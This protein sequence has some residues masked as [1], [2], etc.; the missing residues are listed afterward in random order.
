MTTRKK[1]HKKGGVPVAKKIAE[2]HPKLFHYTSAS[3]LEG[4][5]K[6]Q[7]LWATHAAFLNDSAEIRAF[8]AR[9]PEVLRPAVD[10]GI[11]KLLE[12]PANRELVKKVGGRAAAVDE[13]VRGIA[14]GMYAAL[15]GTSATPPFVEPY[16]LS[17]CTAATRQVT[18]HG[19]LSQWRGYGRDGG[20]AIEF[21]TARLDSLLG[22]EGAKWVYDLF[23]GDV[24]YSSDSSEKLRE[25]LG[26]SIDDIKA[27]VTQFLRTAGE[28]ETL[29]KIYSALI[30]CAC[31]YKHWGFDEEKEVRVVAIPPN[32]EIVQEMKRRGRNVDEKPRRSFLRGGTPVPCIHLFE[33]IAKLPDRPLPITRVIVGPHP[34][35]EKRRRGVEIQLAQY[36]LNIPVSISEI[37]YVG[38]S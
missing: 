18:E 3:G 28:P 36:G 19:L 1:V 24:I 2:V 17:F 16:V 31:R 32:K 8:A 7:T 27:S 33:G 11:D 38:N 5:L 37:P 30:Q 26:Q 12:V 25:E 34:D 4:I 20:Y 29:K 14:T 6:S 23:G 10:G 22:G 15:L 21:E 35:K 9:L 13:V